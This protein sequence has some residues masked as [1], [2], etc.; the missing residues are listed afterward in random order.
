VEI[1][2]AVEAGDTTGVEELLEADPS[3]LEE[4][5]EDGWTPLHLACFYGYSELVT[6]LVKRGADVGKR[7]ANDMRQAALDVAIAGRHSEIVELLLAHAADPNAASKGGW[8][9]LQSA[10]ASGDEEIVRLLLARGADR[11]A[12]LKDGRKAADLARAQGHNAI[13]EL[14]EHA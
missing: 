6:A 1:F 11:N 8:T 10:A 5:S 3:Q 14:I 13:A 7:S 2:E 9:P 12:Q 4:F